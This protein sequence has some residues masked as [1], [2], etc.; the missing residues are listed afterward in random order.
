MATQVS[1]MSGTNTDDLLGLGGV[2]MRLLYALYFV[3]YVALSFSAGQLRYSWVEGCGLLVI[4]ACGAVVSGPSAYPLPI[5]RAALIL[6]ATTACAYILDSHLP[7]A[8]ESGFASWHLGAITF[9]LFTLCL[10]GRVVLGWVG[11]GLLCFAAAIW[12]TIATGDPLFG[13]N[14]A[15]G[16]AASLFAGTFFAILLR[17]TASQILEFQQVEQQRIGQ[18]QLRNEG[19]I[20]RE[21]QLTTLRSLVEGPLL[22][23]ANGTASEGDRA[24]F[25]VLEATLRDSIRARGLQREPLT[26]AVHDARARGSDVVLLD[27]LGGQTDE[28]I[29]QV[30]VE[31]AARQVAAAP[32]TNITLRLSADGDERLLTFVSEGSMPQIFRVTPHR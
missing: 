27:D 32:G 26:S 2:G 7:S 6:V 8:G 14:L 17:H 9:I 29:G 12:S 15:Y 20:E 11:M 24:E 16:Q 19:E 18:E 21:K 30:A 28:H 25:R 4:L 3:T 31:W 22:A 13:L 1:A 23:I 10:R 5:G